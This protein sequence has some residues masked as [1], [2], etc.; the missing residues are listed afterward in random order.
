MDAARLFEQHHA[1]LYRYLVRLTGDPDLAHDAAQEAFTRLVAKPPR[2][3]DPRAWLF[4]VATNVVRTWANA[5]SRRHALLRADA[6][7]ARGPAGNPDP[8]ELAELNERRRLV[9]A[10]L[11]LLSEKER[12]IL[13]MREEGFA[14]REIA[15]AVGT[16][17]GSIG[18]MIARALGKLADVLMLD[19]EAV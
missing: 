9:R 12:T 16:T 4:T 19:A 14:H 7:F 13:L 11:D 1:S 17:T 10:G 6:D 2:D 8:H 3:E 18:T 5:R 15:D